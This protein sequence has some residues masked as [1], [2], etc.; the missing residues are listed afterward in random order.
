MR[1]SLRGIS[2]LGDL[3]I[4]GRPNPPHRRVRDRPLARRL[5]YTATG[6]P[7]V[8][9]VWL[10]RPAG[11]DLIGV[12]DLEQRLVIAGDSRAK[13][14]VERMNLAR[15]AGISEP[16]TESVVGSV[17]HHATESDAAIG[18]EI[19][20]VLLPRR[21]DHSTEHPNALW[22]LAAR[23]APDELVDN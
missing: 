23:H 18:I 22:I 4:D 15:D 2:D 14:E 16:N 13:I 11:L 6:L 10:Y 17:R 8:L 9:E 1:H 21:S 19:Y 3:E 7:D 12:A 5:G 20:Q